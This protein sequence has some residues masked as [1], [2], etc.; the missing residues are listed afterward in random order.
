MMKT[1]IF[2]AVLIFTAFIFVSCS[3]KDNPSNSNPN[4]VGAD[5]STILSALLLPSG[6]A[7][8]D[9]NSQTVEAIW[10]SASPLTV[11]ASAIGDNF[12]GSSFPVTIKSV[13]SSQ[14]IYFLVQ[15]ADA[16]PNYL[17]QP[18]HFHGGDPQT[19]TNWTIDQNTYEDGVSMIFE[20]P[21]NKGMSGT[22]TFTSDGCTML[23]HTTTTSQW[24]KGMFAENAGRYDLWYWHAGKG[25]GSGYADDE[26][27]IGDPNF[28]ISK[29]DG[30][31]EIYDF[32]VNNNPGFKPFYVAG[33]AN[34]NLDKQFFIAEESDLAFDNTVTKN[35]GTNR[36]WV[37]DDVVPSFTLALP[38]D[39]TNDY[40][41]VQAKGYYS[42]G[43]WTVKFQRKLNTG[44]YNLDT[45]F[46]RGNDYLFSFAIHNN[47][48][49]DNHFGAANKSFT[50]K[51]P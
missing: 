41:D 3:S 17:S 49:P 31:A 15:Y 8:P 13:V 28:A 1:H 18:L 6:T 43:M 32:N 11:T 12:S 36:A 27:S 38:T 34:R 33:G 19:P 35:P 10:S 42:N 24:A 22:K 40:F 20:D 45:Q 44:V 21:A 5:T 37:A 46:T 48:S 7:A 16:S 14:N 29:D 25:N 30:N 50:L 2:S 47:N 26:I 39:P 23:C 4:T 9:Y 51:L